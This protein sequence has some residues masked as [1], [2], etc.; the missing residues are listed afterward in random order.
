MYADRRRTMKKSLR[1]C[2][3]HLRESRPN[4]KVEIENVL[5]KL[6]QVAQ[7]SEPDPMFIELQSCPQAFEVGKAIEATFHKL[8]RISQSGAESILPPAGLVVPPLA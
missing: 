4:H 1:R 2:T 3:A 6:R 7:G 5:S 8:A